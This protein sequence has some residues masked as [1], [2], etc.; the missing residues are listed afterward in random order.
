MIS[1][2]FS[3]LILVAVAM[4]I[5]LPA[6]ASSCDGVDNTWDQRKE[7]LDDYV[8][9]VWNTLI[10]AQGNMHDRGYETSRDVKVIRDKHL[11]RLVGEKGTYLF[12]FGNSLLHRRTD[13]TFITN[14]ASQL[15]DVADIYHELLIPGT[16]EGPRGT[17]KKRGKKLQKATLVIQGF[18]NGCLDGGA[19][20]KWLLAIEDSDLVIW[21]TIELSQARH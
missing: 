4:A 20:R 13:I 19:F 9:D 16:F 10:L 21:G 1:R 5:S 15:S 7:K 2:Y 12:R 3:N 14:P 8:G 18:G 6:L 11:V 17:G